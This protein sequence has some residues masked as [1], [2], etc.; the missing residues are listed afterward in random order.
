MKELA[1]KDRNLIVYGL[2]LLFVAIYLLVYY[3]PRTSKL[4]T[5]EEANTALLG[6]RQELAV[7]LPQ[8]ASTAPTVADPSGKVAAFISSEAVRDLNETKQVVAND[9]YLEGKGAKVKLRRLKPDQVA[10]FL[11]SLT[12]IRLVVERMQLQDS[13]GDGLWDL[14]IDLKVPASL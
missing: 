11:A 2:I 1:G 7:L 9:S 8:L 12:K 5:L 14:D 3:F 13:D 6:E 10:S 4:S